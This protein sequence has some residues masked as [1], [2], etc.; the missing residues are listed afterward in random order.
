M[1]TYVLEIGFDP[2]TDEVTYV[3]E[4]IDGAKAVLSL[5]GERIE[6]DDE[7]A[8]FIVNDTIGIC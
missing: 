5:E 1:K 6:L 2:L 7:L 3:K 4:Y 8:D